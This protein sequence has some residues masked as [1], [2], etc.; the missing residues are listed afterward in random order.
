M[1]AFNQEDF[2][3]ESINSI[4]NQTIKDFELIVINDGSSDN[5]LK[6]LG[7]FTDKRIRIIENER[8][9]GLIAS[10]NKG[11]DAARSSPYL[12]RM[13]SDDVALPERFFHQIEVLEKYSNIGIVGTGMRFF[14]K[15]IKERDRFFPESTDKIIPSFLY[16]NPLSHPTVMIRN[17]LF[18]DISLRYDKNFY[19]YEDYKL[20][21]DLINKCDFYNINKRLLFYRRHLNNETHTSNFDF[22]KEMSIKSMLY[23]CYAEKMDLIITE[24]E[25][26]ILGLVSTRYELIKETSI[27][28]NQLYDSINSIINKHKSKNIDINYL[29]QML[30]RRMFIYLLKFKRITDVYKLLS[31]L[32]M[33][34]NYLKMISSL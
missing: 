13:D 9:L 25:K 26:R 31:K 17:E 1:S 28:F 24:E 27:P 21:I 5:T 22:E 4:L 32:K 7:S 18:S 23:K 6:I 33:K 19:R 30:W 3:R 14:G 20:W 34:V 16:Q 8:N 11:I 2:I 15:D 29:S 12:A 10:L